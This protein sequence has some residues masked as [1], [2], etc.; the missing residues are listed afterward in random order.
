VCCRCGMECVSW[1]VSVERVILVGIAREGRWGMRRS[2]RPG[3]LCVLCGVVTMLF[4]GAGAP[5]GPCE[6]SGPQGLGYPYLIDPASGD[7]SFIVVHKPQAGA[8]LA[9]G[10]WEA[11]RY[12]A[13][14]TRDA[15][16]VCASPDVCRTSGGGGGGGAGRAGSRGLGDATPPLGSAVDG[17]RGEYYLLRTDAI[18]L[19][20][21]ETGESNGKLALPSAGDGFASPP[22]SMASGGSTAEGARIFFVVDANGAVWKW[23][24]NI[25]DDVNWTKISD[26]PAGTMTNPK[27]VGG[28]AADTGAKPYLVFT[29][30]SSGSWASQV[31]MHDGADWGLKGETSSPSNRSLD[32][33]A[34]GST[35]L[36]YTTD[37]ENNKIVRFGT[38]DPTSGTVFAGTSTWCEGITYHPGSGRILV[39]GTGD[40]KVYQY[41]LSGNLVSWGAAPSATPSPTASPSASPSPTPSVSPTPSSSPSATP[42]PSASPSPSV[43]PLPTPSDLLEPTPV[44]EGGSWVT[45]PTPIPEGLGVLE[46]AL[47][48]GF[49]F[50]QW[51]LLLILGNTIDAD[52][53]QVVQVGEAWEIR[54]KMLDDAKEFKITLDS[55]KDE[56]GGVSYRWSLF[57]WNNE[58]GQWEAGV[59]DEEESP[60]S[61]GFVARDTQLEWTFEDG[62]S[63]DLDGVQDGFVSLR[64]ASVLLGAPVATTGA[65]EGGG[66]SGCG[67]PS[68]SLPAALLLAPL[69]FLFW[70]F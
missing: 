32:G 48:K 65:P 26:K 70:R 25:S 22:K 50:P 66:G 20:D 19:H 1:S 17:A 57:F 14:G 52:G 58:T 6:A 61:R 63:F 47:P 59:G 13:D 56:Q 9:A 28:N 60:E 3:V 35:G 37:T 34:V 12:F 51:F 44:L 5:C 10:G 45:S 46:G 8:C 49:V 15:S 68:A 43:S 33:I 29:S 39:A 4:F 11:V 18:Y 54:L 55:E 7:G 21:L 67:I 53:V 41:D 27:R 38:G 40:G 30:G 62:G 42:S 23:Q 24:F 2:V 31:Y 36:V 64:R 69:L 16:F